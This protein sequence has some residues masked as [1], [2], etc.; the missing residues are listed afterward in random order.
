MPG[1]S[2]GSLDARVRSCLDSIVSFDGHNDL[3]GAGG[4]EHAIRSLRGVVAEGHRPDPRDLE[5]YVMS[6][7]GLGSSRGS[8]RLREWYEGILEGKSF[9]DY[10]GRKI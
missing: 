8:A 1:T 2:A 3:V 10:A 9:R 6:M 5:A 4:K 7:G